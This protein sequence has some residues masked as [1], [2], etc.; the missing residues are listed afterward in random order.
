MFDIKYMNP[1]VTIVWLIR[2]LQR[3]L[4]KIPMWLLLGIAAILVGVSI[5]GVMIW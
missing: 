1:T 2:K 5:F 4:K 3:V